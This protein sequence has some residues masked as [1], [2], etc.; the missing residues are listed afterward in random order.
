MKHPETREDKFI[1][2]FSE[3]SDPLFYYVLKL[4]GSEEN[5]KDIVQECFTRVWE[6]IEK[7]DMQ[8][9][10][11][12]LLVTYIKN[13][14]R[15][16]YRK[17]KNYKH[18]LSEI[19]EDLKDASLRPA[20]E[21]SLALK[22]RQKRLDTSLSELPEK[23]KNIFRMVRLEGL[24]YKEVAETLHVSVADIKKQMRLSLHHL[25]KAMNIFVCMLFWSSMLPIY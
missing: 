3:Y 7:I 23:C 2:I 14:L 10:I 17:N 5:A 6:N 8:A 21:D 19:G 11:L 12:P 9:A 4:T 22:E 18:L 25:R 16:E 15:D 13:L 20:A 24:S 1:K